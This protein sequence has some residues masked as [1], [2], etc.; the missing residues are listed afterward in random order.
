MY[1]SYGKPPKASSTMFGEASEAAARSALPE[2][3]SE[4]G[5]GG[6]QFSRRNV[7]ASI[8]LFATVSFL[9]SIFAL[10]PNTEP[11]GGAEAPSPSEVLQFSSNLSSQYEL[12]EGELGPPPDGPPP[13][14][15]ET[16]QFIKEMPDRFADVTAKLEAASGN[17]GRGETRESNNSQKP[18]LRDAS[19]GQVSDMAANARSTLKDVNA[20]LGVSSGAAALETPSASGIPWADLG[21]ADLDDITDAEKLRIANAAIEQTAAAFQQILPL[22]DAPGITLFAVEAVRTTMVSRYR[23]ARDIDPIDRNDATRALRRR[24]CLGASMD[25]TLRLGGQYEYVLYDASGLIV[26]RFTITATSCA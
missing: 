25:M 23:I 20:A 11:F 18:A 22:Q 1:R 12:I 4:T 6:P 8:V 14:P 9:L 17:E 10:R 7:I 19:P 2:T 24:A 21:A 15:E 3:V 16:A 13:T 5:S 26:D